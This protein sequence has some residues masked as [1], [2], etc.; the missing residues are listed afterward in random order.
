MNRARPVV[1]RYGLASRQSS[2]TMSSATTSTATPRTLREAPQ[3]RSGRLCRLRGGCGSRRG[4][5]TATMSLAR[6]KY[7]L[8]LHRQLAQRLFH[9]RHHWLGERSV[10]EG[11]GE[12]LPVVLGPPEEVQQ[13]LPLRR[14]GHVLVDQKIREGRD[15]P[16]VLAGL[17]GD[18]D[19]VVVG[20]LGLG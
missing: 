12:L 20:H 8:P 15:R 3:A 6:C 18:G 13:G 7:R 14:V 2:A 11:G 1:A 4:R 19:A 17:V 10:L 9:L 16:G 5:A